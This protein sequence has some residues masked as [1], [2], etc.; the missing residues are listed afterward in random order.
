[1]CDLSDQY[2]HEQKGDTH[3]KGATSVVEDKTQP[4]PRL[5]LLITK[6]IMYCTL[7]CRLIG[8]P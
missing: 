1:M 5:L 8:A 4:A 2:A 3:G 6:V 7:K